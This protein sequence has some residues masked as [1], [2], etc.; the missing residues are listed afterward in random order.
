[1]RRRCRE[2]KA[3]WRRSGR[4]CWKCGSA[5]GT[6]SLPWAGIPCWVSSWSPGCATICAW[7]CRCARCSRR[8]CWRISPITWPITPSLPRGR[9]CC[10]ASRAVSRR[11]RSPSSACGS[12]PSWN[13][14]APPTTCRACC[15]CAAICRWTPCSA[16]SMRWPSAM[17]ACA[18]ASCMASR[19]CR[20][21]GSSKRAASPWPV[22]TCA[23]TRRRRRRSMCWR[24]RS[25]PSPSTSTA[26]ARR[27]AWRWCGW[28]T[29]SGGC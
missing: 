13:P 21:S 26:S 29:T 17:K 3:S 16:A 20:C 27:G 11:S 5:A 12:S 18:P 23:P 8:R 19:A 6:T 15:T 1:M 25:W 4:S 14:T 2:W 24:G 28:A 7:S 22:T 9:R 10:R